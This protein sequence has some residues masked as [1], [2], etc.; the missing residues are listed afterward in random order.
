MGDV[1]AH[2]AEPRLVL[3]ARPRRLEL[4]EAGGEI[5]GHDRDAR[6]GEGG[7]LG[8]RIGAEPAEPDALGD[9]LAFLVE[10]R[11]GEAETDDDEID[12]LDL[13]RE[14]R[15]PPALAP[16]LIADAPG[17]I[18][19]KPPRLARRCDRI[20]GQHQIILGISPARRPGAAL[21]IDER[22]DADRRKQAL[23]RV[24]IARRIML[25]PMDEHHDRHLAAT[26]REDQPALERG[27]AAGEI[28]VALLEVDPTAG[29]PPH[30]DRR[31]VARAEGDIVAV[32]LV[33]PAQGAAP[34]P[35]RAGGQQPGP[36]VDRAP[37][38]LAARR[39]A[40]V[41]DRAI[42]QLIGADMTARRIGRRGGR[43]QAAR[44]DPGP[45]QYADYFHYHRPR[46]PAF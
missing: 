45:D 30:A 14:R 10:R 16:R 8:H 6:V 46:L 15:D 17:A 34:A 9:R 43:R 23:E 44:R 19:G 40:D 18:P 24:E 28:G 31:R 11:D 35:A 25:G 38:Q 2:R 1:A 3:V 22:A 33:G 39:I 26:P 7:G 42:G 36:P 12:R 29:H 27:I 4:V 37:A 13:R 41:D 20:L 5:A 21:V 32:G